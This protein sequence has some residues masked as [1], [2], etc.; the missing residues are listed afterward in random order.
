ME[1]RRQKSWKS[2][3]LWRN[4]SSYLGGLVV[5]GVKAFDGDLSE[6]VGLQRLLRQVTVV[7]DGWMQEKKNSHLVC[8]RL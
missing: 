2:G 3:A 7:N 5:R 1:K 8:S 4:H 6:D